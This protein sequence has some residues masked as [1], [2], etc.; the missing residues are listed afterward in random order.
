MRKITSLLFLIL[1][2]AACSSDNKTSNSSRSR[3]VTVPPLPNMTLVEGCPALELENWVETAY[4]NM[5]SFVNDA[6]VSARLADDNRRN[7]M[8]SVIDRLVLLRNSV[9]SAN[10]PDCVAAR[11]QAIVGD[12]QRVIDDFQ[13]FANTQISASD[14]QRRATEDVQRIKTTIDIILAE[15]APLYQINP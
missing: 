3:D 2:V 7:E 12:M 14:L 6:E 9:N 13:L 4:F 5:Q 11:H 15:T 10:T 8:D 1:V